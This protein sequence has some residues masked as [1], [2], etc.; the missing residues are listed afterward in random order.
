MLKRLVLLLLLPV[1]AACSNQ[2][3]YV[4]TV[5]VL[6]PGSTLSVNVA[7]ATFSAF[8]PAAGQARDRFTVAAT[9]FAKATPPPPPRVRGLARGGVL[10]QAGQPLA[11]LLVRVPDGVTLVVDSQRGRVQVTDITGNARITARQGDVQVMLPGYAQVRAGNG[12]VLVRMG[13]TGWP[14]TLHFS[15]RRGDVEV[16]VNENAA[17]DV[18][19]HTGHGTLFSDFD[20]RG[21]SRGGAETIV[22]RVNGGGSHGIDI[23]TS[24]GEVRLLRLHPQA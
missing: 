18:R 24:A 17:F 2:T 13:S 10:V 15:T 6:S 8:A 9:A 3:P 11:D 16:W 7:N 5:G 19:L 12:N 1:A 22:G 20:L 4:T 14:G 23:E 21:T